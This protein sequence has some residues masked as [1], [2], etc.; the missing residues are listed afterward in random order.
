LSSGTI[1]K[2]Y[3]GVDGL[4]SLKPLCQKLCFGETSDRIASHQ[5]L[6]GTGSLRMCGEFLAEHL[7]KN[8]IYVSDPTWANHSAIFQRAGFAVETYP[9]WNAEKRDFRFEEM[10]AHLKAAPDGSV[11]LL[12]ACAHNPTGVDPTADQ[13]KVIMEACKAK[14]HFAILDSAYQGYATGD[15]VRDRAVLELFLHSGMEFAVCQSFAKNLGLYGERMG[16]LHVVCADKAS[17]EAVNSQVKLVIRASYSSPPLH[18]AHI[19]EKIL[20]QPEFYAQ[21]QKELKEMADRVLEMRAALRQA[22]E[23]KNVP[24]FS[25]W[26]HIT[27]QIG[28]FSYTGLSTAQCE[29]LIKDYHIYLVKSGRI[30]L[31]GLN[32]NNVQYLADSIDAVCRSQPQSKL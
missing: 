17:A 11:Y 20:G 22:L 31:A 9:Y 2:E 6:S 23:A 7:K 27:D 24:G 4:A 29:S 10:V 18:G 19:V 32:K 8:S 28:M 3:L 25:N 1:N 21:W 5:V 16:M 15:L 26:K 30:S 14:G 12:H 13:W